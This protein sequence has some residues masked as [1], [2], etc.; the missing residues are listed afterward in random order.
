MN[1]ISYNCTTNELGIDN[2]S[3]VQ[4]VS[5]LKSLAKKAN[6]SG[7]EIAK[8]MG[9]RPETVSRH[10]NGR[11]N[12]SIDDAI[13]YSRILNCTPEEILFK[14]SMCPMI[15][16]LNPDG[17]MTLFNEDESK[18]R[19]LVGPHTFG[20]NDA[21]YFVPKWFNTRKTAITI[22]NRRPILKRYVDDQCIGNISLC[23]LKPNEKGKDQLPRFIVGVPFEIEYSKF[24]VRR[25]TSMVKAF[26]DTKNTKYPYTLENKHPDQTHYN[27]VELEWATPADMTI[28]DPGRKGFDIIKDH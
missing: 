13:K 3:E 14:R 2:M 7:V 6:L 1:G 10:L 20:D 8:Q 11:Q 28:Y 26:T 12:I 27:N 19:Y 25:M 15:G 21:A 23:C 5:N 17:I 9:F 16:E 22:I 24:T 18:R 4:S